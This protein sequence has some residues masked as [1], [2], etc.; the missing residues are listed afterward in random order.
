VTAA[1]VAGMA[2]FDSGAEERVQVQFVVANGQVILDGVVVFANEFL[3][4]SAHGS[5]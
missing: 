2:E 5:S 3:G 4:K 1:D